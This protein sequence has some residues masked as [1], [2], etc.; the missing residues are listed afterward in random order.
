M[1]DQQ[2]STLKF[3]MAKARRNF[4]PRR[5]PF[6]K[7]QIKMCEM[8]VYILRCNVALPQAAYPLIS[9]QNKALL[10]FHSYQK[11]SKGE[12]GKFPIFSLGMEGNFSKKC[13]FY[14]LKYPPRIPDK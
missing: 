11:T 6:S 12:K 7:K 13:I 4:P 8:R 10:A 3:S 2:G 5:S 14:G 1:H 9:N